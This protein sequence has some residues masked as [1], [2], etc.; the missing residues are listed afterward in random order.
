M[1]LLLDIFGIDDFL[2]EMTKNYPY[3]PIKESA[4]GKHNQVI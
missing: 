3:I 4:F 1:R 2:K